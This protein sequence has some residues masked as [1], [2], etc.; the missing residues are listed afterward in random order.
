MLRPNAPLITELIV[1][2]PFCGDKSFQKT[3]KGQYCLGHLESHAVRMVSTS[4]EVTTTDD[5]KLLQKVC[6]RTEKGDDV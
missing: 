2:C 3:I 1:E 6:I 4:T 5:G